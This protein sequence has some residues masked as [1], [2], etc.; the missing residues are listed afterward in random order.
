[1]LLAYSA[2]VLCKVLR[3]HFS[4]RSNPL[5]WVAIRRMRR[6]SLRS[7]ARK[8]QVR[9]LPCSGI[10][11]SPLR[12][13]K[14]VGQKCRRFRD[15]CTSCSSHALSLRDISQRSLASSALRSL[16]G[17]H[18]VCPRGERDIA[19]RRPSPPPLER[20]HSMANMQNQAPIAIERARAAR[21]LPHLRLSRDSW[22]SGTD[23]S[24][25]L[26]RSDADRRAVVSVHSCLKPI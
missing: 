25:A 24:L 26:L 12:S 15:P 17:P 7:E 2:S 16:R 14:E 3:C 21:L 1:M 22:A 19:A 9:G 6:G 11:A 13:W 4:V 10:Q 18:L 5:K 8:H 20:G 23:P